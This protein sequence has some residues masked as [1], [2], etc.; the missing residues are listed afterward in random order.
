MN[1]NQI[2]NAVLARPRNAFSASATVIQQKKLPDVSYYQGNINW[3]VLA[4]K[5]NAVIIRAGH[6]TIEDP[7]FRTNW[8]EAKKRGMYRGVYWFYDDPVSPGTQAA[9]LYE[10][11]R[12]DPPEMETW[13]DWETTY[14]GQ[15]AGL[16]NVVAMM[17]SVESK[18]GM[19]CTGMYTGYYWFTANSNPITHSSQYKYLAERPL[20]LAWY[21]NDPSV[22][23]IPAP[24]KSLLFWQYGTPVLGGEYGVQSKE[25]DMNYFNGTEEDFVIRYGGEVPPPPPASS[26]PAELIIGQSAVSGALYRRVE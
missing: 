22:V 21:I 4:S 26:L 12:F 9:K 24:W 1:A 19:R 25:I 5:T 7:Q 23:K 2:I 6:G 18:M 10:M 11:I 17:E 8:A 15:F 16:K 20:W 3:D 13:I 14:K